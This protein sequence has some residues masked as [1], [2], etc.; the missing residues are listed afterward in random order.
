MVDTIWAQAVEV[1]ATTGKIEIA[2]P[3]GYF[4]NRFALKR[5][6]QLHE[7]PGTFNNKVTPLVSEQI[8]WNAT[9]PLQSVNYI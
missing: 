3:C 8:G 7:H 4:A 5:L 9:S 2:Y 6:N 1:H